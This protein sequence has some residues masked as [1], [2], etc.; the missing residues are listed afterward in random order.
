[1]PGN[2]DIMVQ[3]W[4]RRILVVATFVLTAIPIWAATATAASLCMPP[5][6]VAG[7]APE[8]AVN[9]RYVWFLIE[10][11]AHAHLAWQKADDAVDS[12]HPAVQLAD[13]KLAVEDFQCAASLVQT[14]QSARGPD[15]HTTKAIHVSA[16]A[17]TAAYKAFATGFQRWATA[18]GHGEG[19]T[20]EA[21]ADLKIQ[22]E[23]AGELLIHAAAAAWFSLLE[24]PPDSKTPMDRLSLTRAHCAALLE[25][26][27]RRG[28]RS[29]PDL[30]S[31][32][33]HTPAL[34]AVVLYKG[35]SSPEYKAFDDP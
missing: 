12:Q 30:H 5:V 18:L 21:A 33:T 20:L 13:L 8:V 31:P 27:K 3:R 19:L 25:G 22:N 16:T 10:S 4:S 23:K 34:A 7:A 9:H 11:L 14:F 26:L 29:K 35:L 32:D 28:F 24:P 17:A 15:G 1:M 6:E 2:R